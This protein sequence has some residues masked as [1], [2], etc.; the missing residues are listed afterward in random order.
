MSAP[1][2]G[3]LGARR[4]RQGL[5]PF[6]ARWLREAGA[7]VPC[8][9]CTSQE[10]VDAAG[11]DLQRLAGVTAKGWVDGAAM[12]REETLD[13]VAILTPPRTHRIWLERALEAGLDV[14]CEKPFLW[15][16]D[17]DLAA[18]QGLVDRFEAAGLMLLENAQWPATLPSFD[19]LHPGVR[20]QPVSR[21]AM[22]MAPAS[23]GAEMIGDALPHPLS[24]LQALAPSE[25]VSVEGCRFST[26]DAAATELSMAFRYLADGRPIDVMVE[27]SASPE[28]PREASLAIDGHWAHRLIRLSDYGQFFASGARVVDVPDPLG[29]HLA[30]FVEA[31]RAERPRVSALEN[32][33]IRQRMAALDTVRRAFLDSPAQDAP[34]TT[35]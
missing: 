7:E 32:I 33:K 16:A 10:T 21:F 2:V 31:L 22:R 34:R 27:L 1:R 18:A 29:L 4:H 23:A 5:G 11:A 17:D 25:T 6:V 8:F 13:A 30:G 35:P 19:A 9:A 14:L 15:G 28:Q 26:H 3:I 20:D 12:L 24:V